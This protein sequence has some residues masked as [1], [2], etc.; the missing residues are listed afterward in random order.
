MS[1][2]CAKCGNPLSENEKFCGK[3]GA[4]VANDSVVQAQPYVDPIM[5]AVPENV[6]VETGVG[7]QGKSPKNKALLAIIAAAALVVIVVAIVIIANVTKY[8][9]IDAKELFK[10]DFKGLNGSGKATAVLNCEM[11]DIISSIYSDD[12]EEK[13]EYSDYFADDR[14]TLMKVYTKADDKGEAEDMRDALMKVNK[15]T[16]EFELQLDLSEDE[17]LSNGDKITCTVDYDEEELKEVNIKLTNTEFEIEVKGLKEAVEI[18]MFDDFSVKFSGVD[19]V[20]TAEFEDESAKYPFISYYS[21]TSSYD[22]SNGDTYT[23]SAYIDSSETEDMNY[24]DEEDPD[25]GRYFTFEDKTY[26][27]KN[28]NTTKDFVVEGLTEPEKIDVFEGITLETRGAVP[29]LRLSTINTDA[30]SDVVKSNVSFY[31][32]SDKTYYNVGDKVL[33]KARV[34]SY[35]TDEGYKAEGTTDSDGYYTKEIE[36]T[37]ETCSKYFTDKTS[38]EDYAKLDVFFNEKAAEYKEDNIDTTYLSG[39][40]SFSDRVKSYTSFEPVSTYVALN[41]GFNE[42]TIS[43][44]DSKTYVY[45]IFKAVVKLDDAK[46]S[47]KTFYVAMRIDSPYITPDGEATLDSDY[48]SVSADEKLAD[49][50][51][52]YVKKDKEATVTEIKKG[53]AANAS[54][55]SSKPDDSSSKADDSSDKADDSSSK[56]DDDS[57]E[58]VP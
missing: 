36:I 17:K 37:E 58:L 12:E 43:I 21:E 44:Y 32:D 42:G 14:K 41:E 33:V 51:K 53:Q 23:V 8:Q 28:L 2:F 47:S 40:V 54:G 3:C 27:V 16:G 31:V 45:R 30:C 34:S 57:S 19:S 5:Q 25:A 15:K 18:D 49:L 9:K 11:N 46:K 13:P 20:G 10:I 1:K 38:A 4:S 39:G 6:Q 35:L 24:I 50:I 55:N 26:F 29:Y 52:N 22:L 56:A 48:V 7:A